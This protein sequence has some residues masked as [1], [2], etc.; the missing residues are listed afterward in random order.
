M[1]YVIIVFCLLVGFTSCKKSG[2][3]DIVVPVDPRERMVGTYDLGYQART[4]VATLEGNPEPGTAV[5]TV[6]KSTQEN[7]LILDFVFNAT[8]KEQLIAQ[9]SGNKFTITNKKTETIYA[10]N[11][12]F[13]APYTGNGEFTAANE[14]TMVTVAETI[15]SG[16][17]IKRVGSIAGTKR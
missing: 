7:E 12:S 15:Q 2:G 14:F 1:K 16:T 8:V 6:T 13:D 5:L 9:L 4:T 3:T 10:L 11:K 17:T